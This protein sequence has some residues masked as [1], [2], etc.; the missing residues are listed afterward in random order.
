MPHLMLRVIIYENG[1]AFDEYHLLARTS[2][3]W[4]TH[5]DSFATF[6]AAWIEFA[7]DTVT[8]KTIFSS[9][10]E[11]RSWNCVTAY[12][13]LIVSIWDYQIDTF[14]RIERIVILKWL[15]LNEGCDSETSLKYRSIRRVSEHSLGI[16]TIELDFK[17]NADYIQVI[18]E[19][20]FMKTPIKKF[21]SWLSPIDL[22]VG[23]FSSAE[24][25]LICVIK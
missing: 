14:L 25:Q 23:K 8:V 9:F 10:S 4:R 13:F 15:I 21:Q 16:N 5:N 11:Q 18:L 20:Y 7:F 6:I 1:P 17:W 2:T 19:I 12:S 24:G 22:C 3:K